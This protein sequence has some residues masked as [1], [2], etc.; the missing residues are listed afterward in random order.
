MARVR[1]ADYTAMWIASCL[2]GQLG[3]IG[4]P[5]GRGRVLIPA[6]SKSTGLMLGQLFGED[7]LS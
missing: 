7:R 2:P 4:E 3:I 6:A 1:D 5:L